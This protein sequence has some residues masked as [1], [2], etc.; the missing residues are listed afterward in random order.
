MGDPVTGAGTTPTNQTTNASQSEAQSQAKAQSLFDGVLKSLCPP[1]TYLR[2]QPQPDLQLHK[3]VP[4]NLIRGPTNDP[5][6][7]G[8]DDYKKPTPK[9]EEK[10]VKVP[11][12]PKVPSSMVP[13]DK[14]HLGGWGWPF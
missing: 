2:P 12:G 8:G 1:C 6:G 4:P 9:L 10:G 5:N 3:D 11:D 13:G 14:S 7:P